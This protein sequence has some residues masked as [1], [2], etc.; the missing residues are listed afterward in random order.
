MT[1]TI[2]RIRRCNRDSLFAI[3]QS[4]PVLAARPDAKPQNDDG[5]TRESLFDRVED[6]QKLQDECFALLSSD[7][8]GQAVET[9]KPMNIGS[10]I[11][12]APRLPRVR[13]ID[14]ARNLDRTMIVSGAAVD[15]NAERNSI[16]AIG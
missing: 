2:E 7:R 15:H 10:D 14:K 8:I 16:E 4:L 3:S 12:V 1:A 9:Q 13:L 6:A 5:F 11:P